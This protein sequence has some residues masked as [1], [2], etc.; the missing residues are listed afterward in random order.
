MTSGQ[1]L[2]TIREEMGFSQ[3]D[4]AEILEVSQSWI[5][6]VEKHDKFDLDSRIIAKLTKTVQIL[7]HAE[8]I[9]E[10]IWNGSRF[11]AQA[12][13]RTTEESDH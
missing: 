7:S 13:V 11:K 10:F 4:M 3:I 8:L 6:R 12:K 1:L 5:S 2:K 9:N